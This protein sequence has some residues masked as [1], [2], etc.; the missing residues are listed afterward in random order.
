ML[1]TV[2]TPINIKNEAENLASKY[3]G[4]ISVKFLSTLPIASGGARKCHFGFSWK[5][6]F[7][8]GK[9]DLNTGI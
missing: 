7:E 1:L 3:P 4:R 5:P 9:C 6:R 8:S 2:V